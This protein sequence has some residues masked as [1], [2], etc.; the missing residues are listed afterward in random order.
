M[1]TFA[2]TELLPHVVAEDVLRQLGIRDVT[3]VDYVTDKTERM[4]ATSE[5]FRAGLSSTDPRAWYRM[6]VEHWIRG[7]HNR[8]MRQ[9]RSEHAERR[10][11]P[12]CEAS[13]TSTDEQAGYCTNCRRGLR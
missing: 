8:R 5:R 6:W 13:I 12:S 3:L 9:A 10:Y 4:Y 7:E 1:A 2:D 11:C